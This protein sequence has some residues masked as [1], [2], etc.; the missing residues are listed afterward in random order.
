MKGWTRSAFHAVKLS[1]R[2]PQTAFHLSAVMKMLPFR[3]GMPKA[4]A[5]SLSG[6]G[7]PC[8]YRW[9]TRRHSDFGTKRAMTKYDNLKHPQFK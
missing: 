2:Y 9:R 6:T 3:Q 5:L 4:I 8:H 7:K 1:V